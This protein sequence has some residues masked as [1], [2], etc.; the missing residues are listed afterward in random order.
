MANAEQINAVEPI[1]ELTLDEV[2]AVS[3]GADGGGPT[4]VC[5]GCGACGCGCTNC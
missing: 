2:Q 1:R 3:G 4:P 5:C